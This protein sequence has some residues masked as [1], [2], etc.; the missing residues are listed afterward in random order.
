MAGYA[1]CVPQ[2]RAHRLINAQVGSRVQGLGRGGTGVS[3]R[4]AAPLLQNLVLLHGR[5][6]IREHKPKREQVLWLQKSE[7]PPNC[8]S[9]WEHKGAV[10][11]FTAACKAQDRP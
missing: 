9:C 4:M 5:K 2:K 6:G 8:R 11:A 7:M 10:E 3:L 1:E